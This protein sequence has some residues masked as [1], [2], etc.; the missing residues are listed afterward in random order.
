M[1][2]GRARA[3]LSL[4]WIVL[5]CPIILIISIQT[6]LG[7]YGEDWD[8]PWSWLLSLIFPTLSL[9]VAVW[10]V[11]TATV[12]E[13]PVRSMHVFWGAVIISVFYL[14]NLYIAVILGHYSPLTIERV[15]KASAWYLVPLQGLVTVA[16]GKFFVENI[17]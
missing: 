4:L 6:V 5:T 10:T 17:E 3:I 8:L 7:V 13:K 16:L 14:T 11:S 15:L 12:T 9:V 1:T 2:I